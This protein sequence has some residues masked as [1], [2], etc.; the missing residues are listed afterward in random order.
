MKLEAEPVIYHGC[1]QMYQPHLSVVQED[2]VTEDLKTEDLM[3]KT[4]EVLNTYM[5]QTLTNLID[6][7][8]NR[9]IT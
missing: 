4:H 5:D 8:P 3:D 9:L 2:V 1:L 6:I 7:T